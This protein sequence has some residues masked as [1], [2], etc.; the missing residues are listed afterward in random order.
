VPIDQAAKRVNW[1]EWADKFPVARKVDLDPSC[2]LTKHSPA[3]MMD[4]YA[5]ASS[6]LG[7]LSARQAQ[8]SASFRLAGG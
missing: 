8:R 2:R 7:K 3:G 5:S 4:A 6:A 1:G